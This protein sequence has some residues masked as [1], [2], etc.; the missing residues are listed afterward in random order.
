[1]RHA[2]AVRHHRSSTFVAAWREL[3]SQSRRC[4]RPQSN[5]TE[6]TNNYTL[7]TRYYTVRSSAIQLDKSLLLSRRMAPSLLSFTVAAR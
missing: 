6:Q 2:S 4:R 7:I 5:Y 3:G 1:M